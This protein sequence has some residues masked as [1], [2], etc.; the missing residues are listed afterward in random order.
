[1]SSDTQVG[2]DIAACL[3]ILR[4]F[5]ESLG[6]RCDGGAPKNMISSGHFDRLIKSTAQDPNVHDA[7]LKCSGRPIRRTTK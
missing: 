7:L 5:K 3:W 6:V 4:R 1:M 2:T